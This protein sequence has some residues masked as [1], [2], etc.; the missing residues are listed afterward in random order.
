[1]R[2]AGEEGAWL[3]VAEKMGMRYISRGEGDG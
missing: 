2:M 3:R 1:M